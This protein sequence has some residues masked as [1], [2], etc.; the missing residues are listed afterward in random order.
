MVSPLVGIA[1]LCLVCS[2]NGQQ[3]EDLDSLINSVF[4]RPAEDKPTTEATKPVTSS[5]GINLQPVES[6]GGETGIPGIGECNCVPYY[7]CNNGSINT[8]G[9][10]IIDIRINEGPC[11]NQYIDVCCDK[12][13]T[14][15]EPITPTPN[16]NTVGCGHRNSRGAGVR[17]TGATDGEAEFGEFPW[18]VAILR[19]E[20][21]EG[22][23]LKLNVYQCGGS[24]I[25]PQVALTAAHCV[26]GKNKVFKVRAGEWDTQHE[27]ELYPFQDREVQSIVVHPQFYAG[28]LYNDIALLFLK[29]PVSAAEHIST[30]CLPSQNQ[31]PSGSGF[32]TGWGKDQFGKKGKYQVI[33]KKIEL[34]VVSNNICQDKLRTTRLGRFFELH[35]SFMCAGGEPGKDTCKGDGGSPFV[36]STGT[37]EDKFYQAG[38]V[39]WGIGCGENG[40]PGVYVNIAKF[41]SWIDEQ[42]A[43]QNLDTSTYKY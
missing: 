28:A 26:A 38:I 17:I 40:T 29:S 16:T 11:G 2:I 19:E 36:L 34:P 8:N 12:K 4:S 33:L 6:H 42:M 15:D 31:A 41:R 10:G 37:E 21:V 1:V 5:P 43:K 35:N 20:S 22:N 7:L 18:M 32:A 30:V 9:E 23:P 14:V 3:G 24:L 39:A 27:K 13:N 25:H